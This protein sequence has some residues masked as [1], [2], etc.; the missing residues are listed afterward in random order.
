VRS[1]LRHLGGVTELLLL[2]FD[3]DSRQAVCRDDRYGV[4]FADDPRLRP[5]SEVFAEHLATL[6]D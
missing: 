4:P 3:G 5:D 6:N 1:W 2:G